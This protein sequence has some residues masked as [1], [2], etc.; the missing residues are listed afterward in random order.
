MRAI[1]YMRVFF[2][3]FLCRANQLELL[4]GMIITG[5]VCVLQLFFFRLAPGTVPYD[6]LGVAAFLALSILCALMWVEVYHSS[7]GIGQL[8]EVSMTMFAVLASVL[9]L[10]LF[11]LG[12][13]AVKCRHIVELAAD[14][15]R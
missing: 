5:V 12:V 1:N 13:L 9:T 10:M 15:A 6:V 7:A 8:A 3:T 11:G 4:I 14:V 2:S